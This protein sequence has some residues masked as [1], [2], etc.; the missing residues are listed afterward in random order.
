M[1]DSYSELQ[2]RFAGLEKENERLRQRLKDLEYNPH[3]SSHPHRSSVEEVMRETEHNYE[4]LFMS[5]NQG[6]LYQNASGEITLANPAA[7]EILGLTLD[8][9]Q[10]RTSMDPRWRSIHE[11]GSD[12][13]GETHPIVEARRTGKP[14]RN[15]IMG[16]YHPIEDSYRWVEIDAVPE[17]HPGELTPYQV[18][19]TFTDIT[20]LKEEA[21]TLKANERKFRS[22]IESAPI[23]IFIVDEESHF[24][25]INNT[26]CQMFG[27]E[28][29]S[30]IGKKLFRF[31]E[32]DVYLP[33]L[34]VVENVKKTG[35]HSGELHL[36]LKN[37]NTMHCLVN[38]VKLSQNQFLAF[39]QNIDEIKK[40][41]F[42]LTEA[43][44]KAETAA[45]VKT[46]ILANMSHEV[47]T[48]MVSIMGYSE[49]I[50]HEN[51]DPNIKELV[52]K[53]IFGSRRLLSTMDLIL[54]MSRLESGKVVAKSESFDLVELMKKTARFYTLIAHDKGLELDLQIP[55][56]RPVVIQ[57]K[58]TLE[59]AL[60]NILNN[61]IKFTEKGKIEIQIP[62][63]PVSSGVVEI[64]VKDTGIGIPDR[65]RDVIFENFRQA[66][67]GQGRMYEGTGLGLSVSKKLMEIAGG[68]LIL[69]KSDSTGSTFRLSFPVQVERFLPQLPEEVDQGSNK[70]LSGIETDLARKFRVLIVEDEMLNSTIIREHL[71]TQYSVDIA[72]TGEAALLMLE[73]GEYDLILADINLG[74]GMTGVELAAKVKADPK[75]SGIS[76]IAMTAYALEGDMEE[77]LA[78][79]C[80]DY[81]SK[82]FFRQDILNLL[83]KHL[84]GRKK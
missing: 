15:V 82:P 26:L 77:F 57:D 6:V 78:A 68:D 13:P 53:I 11:D 65:L 46:S 70:V 8:Q 45:R 62:K 44:E 10:G 75:L 21:D 51:I 59:Q 7:Q 84:P 61:A 35:H 56:E 12:F 63:F 16:V 1:K 49:L 17:F 4:T 5:M 43:K 42:A 38:A 33:A 39:I 24:L 34:Q 36:R 9:L 37:G 83:K 71:K 20:T 55:R 23:G 41:Q 73:V 31:V 52:E 80:D 18:F 67:E 81:I 50:Y 66:S 47:R 76:V 14:V 58:N 40:V 22:Y 72:D 28:R 48:P 19:V 29:E 30:L 69:L 27:L 60:H 32:K 25:E 79:G 2:K 54:D 64:L 3:V 74:G